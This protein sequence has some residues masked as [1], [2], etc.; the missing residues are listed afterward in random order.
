MSKPVGV[1]DTKRIDQKTR[2]KIQATQIVKR[3]QDHILA[4]E[5]I[6]TVSQVNASRVLLNK[7]L[8]DLKA[9]EV[10]G[11]PDA[12]LNGNYTVEFIN[13]SCADK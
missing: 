3:L 11:N 10:S 13:A 4:D 6:M 12:P 8:P 5:D 1:R 9:V 2:D 7:I